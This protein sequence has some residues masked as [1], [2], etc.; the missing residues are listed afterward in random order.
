MEE[1]RNVDEN[2]TNVTDEK[3]DANLENVNDMPEEN[4][5]DVENEQGL[6]MK[7]GRNRNECNVSLGIEK[8]FVFH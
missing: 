2:L 5:S 8:G 6:Q 1:A 4:L 7:L 3:G